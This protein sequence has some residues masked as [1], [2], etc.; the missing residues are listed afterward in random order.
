MSD[1]GILITAENAE[2]IAKVKESIEQL[3]ELGEEA[4]KA[5]EHHKSSFAKMSESLESYGKWAA[6]AAV[7]AAALFKIQADAINE[8]AD[9]AAALGMTYE[10]LE[11]INYAA[12][13]TGTKHEAINSAVRKMTAGLGEAAQKGIGPAA[14]ALHHLGLSADELV[15]EKPEENFQKIADGIAKI[16]NPTERATVAAGLFG[17]QWTEIMPVLTLGMEKTNEELESFH[18]GLTN[19]DLSQVEQ[20]NRTMA[21]V[22]SLIEMITHKFTAEMAPAMQVVFQDFLD[23][24]RGSD[25]WGDKTTRAAEA[26][27]HGIAYV[28]DGLAII[29]GAFD[30][31]AAL[32]MEFGG[33]GVEGARLIVAGLDAI[34]EPLQFVINGYIMAYNVYAKWKGLAEQ[35]LLGNFEDQEAKLKKFADDI[36]GA[37]TDLA[38]KG[39]EELAEGF[40]GRAGDAYLEKVKKAKEEAAKEADDPK[41]AKYA[42]VEDLQKLAADQEKLKKE[43]EQYQS[44]IL[45]IEKEGGENQLKYLED[46]YKDE[47]AKLDKFH[48]DGIVKDEQYQKDK[49][50]IERSYDK[51]VADYRAKNNEERAAALQAI[52]NIEKATGAAHSEAMF[53]ALDANHNLELAKL[54]KFRQQELITEAEFQ[55]AKLALD[56]D[57]Q[58]QKAD[59]WASGNQQLL[60]LNALFQKS[61]LEGE[62]GTAATLLDAAGSHSRKA[63][64]LSKAA[65]LAQAAITLPETVMNAYNAGMLA[66]GPAGPV[67]GAAYAAVALAT[68]L[69]Q[70]QSIRSASFGG[71]ASGG[72]AGAAGGAGGAAPAAAA[73]AG[74]S[75]FVS[76]NLQGSESATYSKTQVRDLI[77]RI[78]TEIKDGA[79]LSIR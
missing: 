5:G 19:L 70:I 65:K 43:R 52:A 40:S 35:P 46:K 12:D 4:E 53:K 15:N 77:S 33:A 58:K 44:F 6:A 1:L 79:T 78:N 73:P 67:V 7:A 62:I 14:D 20:A 37:A 50:L 8:Q 59:E 66:G 60:N 72:T 28:Y 41:Q 45:G 31:A 26:I 64:E 3:K 11:R 61:Q 69:A 13:I 21:R 57:Y 17:K 23:L 63:F 54:A 74:P 30:G 38:R 10:G 18:L 76:V 47:L 51:Q 24:G 9:L 68:Q 34:W 16:Q 39:G 36:D 27:T 2:M 42:K 29:K 55:K 49:L 32:A 22:V 48:K 25:T 75:R 56:K 71:G